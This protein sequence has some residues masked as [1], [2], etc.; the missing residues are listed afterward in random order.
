MKNV[1][2][3]AAVLNSLVLLIADPPPEPRERPRI[4]DETIK[5]VEERLK[6]A[7]ASESGPTTEE[8]AGAIQLDTFQVFARDDYFVFDHEKRRPVVK[9]F[10]WK[11]GGTYWRS[12]GP[13]TTKELKIQYDPEF[14]T[15]EFFSIS[16]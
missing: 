7:K 6:K 5:K 12:V 1:L 13:R 14:N 15:V 11:E 10:T 9:P 2:L 8:V 16:F 4:T 3:V